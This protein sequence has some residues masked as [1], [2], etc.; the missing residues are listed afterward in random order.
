MASCWK[1]VTSA[2]L[3]QMVQLAQV[4][5]H[6]FKQNFQAHSR[7]VFGVRDKRLLLRRCLLG[8]FLERLFLVLL[9]LVIFFGRAKILVI[10]FLVLVVVLIFFPWPWP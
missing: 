2:Q 6:Y 5:N 7:G 4:A 1:A 3:V 8:F 9:V 10:V